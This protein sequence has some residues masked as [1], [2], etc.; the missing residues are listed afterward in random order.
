MSKLQSIIVEKNK[1]RERETL[2][3]AEN[4][5]ESIAKKQAQIA[6][7]QADIAAL[8]GDLTK[9]EVEQ[10]DATTILGGE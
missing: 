2:Y 5:I 7:I 3:T 1:Q 9:L 8:R 6:S 10:I 4:I